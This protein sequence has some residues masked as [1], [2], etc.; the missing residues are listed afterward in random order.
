M[1]TSQ[2]SFGSVLRLHALAALLELTGAYLARLEERI[3]SEGL[4]GDS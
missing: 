1:S 3:F 2:P 4:Q